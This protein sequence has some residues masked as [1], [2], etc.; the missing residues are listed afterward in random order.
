L[1][2]TS[3]KL[4][5]ESGFY[6]VIRDD[7]RVVWVC[8]HAGSKHPTR[9]SANACARRELKRW[10]RAHLQ[11]GIRPRGARGYPAAAAAPT[12]IQAI[13]RTTFRRSYVE[14]FLQCTEYLPDQGDN[15]QF[16]IMV[17]DAIHQY[18]R[19]CINER[20]ESKTSAVPGVV[21]D[22]YARAGG[23]HPDRLDEAVEMVDAFARTRIL[24][25][26]RLLWVENAP[27]LEF[28]LSATVGGFR[29]TGTCDRIDRMDGDDPYDPPRFILI[30][31]YKTQWA[32]VEHTFQ[33]RFYAALAFLDQRINQALEGVAVEFDHLPLR[34]GLVYHPG[35][36]G[37]QLAYFERGD[38]DH[39]F[40]DVIE[41]FRRRYD[42]PR[43]KPVGGMS[44][45]YCV[46]RYTCAAADL[47]AN[48]TPEDSDQAAE[49]LS[50]RM[51]SAERA[52]TINAALNA[53][54][55]NHKPDVFGE[56]EV[57]YLLPKNPSDPR[58]WQVTDDRGLAGELDKRGMDGKSVLVTR[59]D[60]KLIPTQLYDM[61]VVANVA[62][63]NQPE[64]K[65]RIRLA[66]GEEEG[67]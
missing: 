45:Q 27:A 53:Y 4:P 38:L 66:S 60:K 64:R 8:D 21:R 5:G 29:Y 41:I 42:G 28:Q 65:F 39:W 61:L 34:N 16:G 48:L 63:W 62:R 11:A 20:V 51:R 58:Y 12:A 33:G 26:E 31:D 23:V 55:K 59:V 44:C 43:G 37:N 25:A 1:K 6:A 36:V 49:L 24:E 22:A 10:D 67:E 7:K 46:K 56:L 35:K 3:R 57:G 2:A 13:Q 18:I 32:K 15:A 52:K 9:R 50:D 14:N 19:L 47:V 54:Y 40:N 17:H 30:R